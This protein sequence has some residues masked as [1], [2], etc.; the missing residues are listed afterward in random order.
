MPRLVNSL[1]LLLILLSPCR[2]ETKTTPDCLFSDA[3]FLICKKYIV[4]VQSYNPAQIF[5]FDRSGKYLMKI[6]AEGKG[7]LEYSSMSN[8]VADPEEISTLPT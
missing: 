4:V 8:S 7:P 6:G 2:H 1:F 3:S 5:L